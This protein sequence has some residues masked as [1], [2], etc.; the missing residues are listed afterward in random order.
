MTHHRKVVSLEKYGPD[1][2]ELPASLVE[3]LSRG[4]S[5]PWLEQL[6]EILECCR[7]KWGLTL[8]RAV[9]EIKRSFVG[10]ALLPDGDQAILK[11]V[12]P[13]A[14]LMAQMEALT[15]YD[16]RGITRVIDLNKE[17]GATLLERIRPG[18][19]LAGHPDRAER[20]EITGQVLLELHKTPPPAAHGLPH[21]Q[22]WM[23]EAFR[24]I[25]NC[26]DLE[27]SR[28]YLDQMPRARA[29]LDTLKAPEE[30]QQLLHGDLHHWNIL[31]DASRGWVAID[32]GGVIGASCLDVGRFIGNAVNF[33]DH[34]SASEIR[35]ILLESIRIL[36]DVLG[37]SE[38]RMFAG[39]FCDKITSS[40]WGFDKPHRKYDEVS[41]RVLQVMVEVG[42]DVDDGRIGI[43]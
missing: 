26:T 12:E 8:G 31:K 39:A 30:P 5:N 9:D 28:P 25:R 33:D 17:L 14:D 19:M 29:M 4:G 22:A 16:G 2:P 35:V 24:D 38:E 3:H 41:Q 15:I 20:A 6:P 23:D 36:S 43:R 32:P 11:V 1:I 10:F 34:P 37:E 40:G 21:F 13:D 42:R 18:T 27:R 7:D